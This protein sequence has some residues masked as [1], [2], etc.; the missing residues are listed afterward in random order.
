M[1]WGDKTR[2]GSRVHKNA[3]LWACINQAIEDI[4][5]G[6][7]QRNPE[8]HMGLLNEALRLAGEEVS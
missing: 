2:A 8:A 4:N 3:E 1:T 7:D 5:N 6:D